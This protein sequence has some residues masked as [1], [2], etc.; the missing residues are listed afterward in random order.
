MYRMLDIIYRLRYCIY[1]L[2]YI[3][4]HK[5]MKNIEKYNLL[6]DNLALGISKM[7]EITE[8]NSTNT[9]DFEDAFDY[10]LQQLK[11][12]DDFFDIY[13]NSIF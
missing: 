5:F 9:K 11:K 8:R 4:Y 2:R 10:T 3:T 1:Y 13:F 7:A 12:F 6:R